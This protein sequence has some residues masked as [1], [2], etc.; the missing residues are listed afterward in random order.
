[1]KIQIKKKNRKKYEQNILKIAFHI[2]QHKLGFVFLLAPLESNYY[3]KHKEIN[4]V[5]HYL[6]TLTSTCFVLADIVD[7]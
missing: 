5:I 4:L 6:N 1:M 2:A 7:L 3:S